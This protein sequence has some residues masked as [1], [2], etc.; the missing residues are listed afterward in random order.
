[1]LLKARVESR[2]SNQ[3][4]PADDTAK[5][6][7]SLDDSDCQLPRPCAS[8]NL[9]LPSLRAT[10]WPKS[11]LQRRSVGAADSPKLRPA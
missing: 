3:A 8:L 11:S 7:L 1:M 4:F 6:A 9:N 10:L 2:E 5:A